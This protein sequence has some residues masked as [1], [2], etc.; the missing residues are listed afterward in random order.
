MNMRT[1]ITIA[2]GLMATNTVLAEPMSSVNYGVAWSVVDGGGNPSVSTNY[3]LEGSVAQPSPLSATT[4]SDYVAT[5]GFF[6]APD[7]DVDAVRDFMDNC[8]L[9]PNI[10]QR[11]TN[12]DGFGNICDA[13]LNNDLITNFIDLNLMS[14]AF[15]SN[16]A[17]PNW[18]EDAD[19]NGD[20]FV[21]FVDLNQMSLAFFGQPGPSG[22]EPD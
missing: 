3:G 13:D 6:G 16:P 19:L 12:I 17:S 11:D 4:S 1:G 10:D 22:I 20:D 9:D 8:T 21:N 2:L 15:F 5:P 7:S 14:D 18:D